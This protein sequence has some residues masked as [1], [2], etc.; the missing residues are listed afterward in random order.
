MIDT[1]F[2][3]IY[4]YTEGDGE[5]GVISN[6]RSYKANVDFKS[7]IYTANSSG[8]LEKI[9]AF[10]IIIGNAT[11][12]IGNYIDIDSSAYEVTKAEKIKN[13]IGAPVSQ[14]EV[15]VKTDARGLA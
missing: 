15:T 4:D 10:I 3:D 11:V 9:A 13:S 12:A 6:K 14:T 5:G 7:G 1:H 8:E 2:I